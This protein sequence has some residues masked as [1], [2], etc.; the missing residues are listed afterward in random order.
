WR[1][2]IETLQR[3]LGEHPVREIR[4][5]SGAGSPAQAPSREKAVARIFDLQPMTDTS[6]LEERGISGETLAAP[7]F[8]GAI[9]NQTY[10][11]R[12]TSQTFVNTVF[13]LRNEQGTVPV[14]LRNRGLNIMDGTK[15]DAVWL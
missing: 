8:Q 4:P 15:G 12:K 6:Y 9:F 14:I 5:S 11:S 3:Y 10:V 2:T 1:D 13:P 7:E